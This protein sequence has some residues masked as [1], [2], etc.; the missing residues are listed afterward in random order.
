MEG[1]LYLCPT[2]IGNLEDITLRVIHTLEACQA[3]YCEDTRRTGQLLRHLGVAK[4]LVSCH[5]HNEAQRG[6]EIVE[7]VLAGEAIAYASDAGMP[8][9]SDPGERLIQRCQAAGAPYEVL[10][11]PSASLTALV[12]SGL[13]S[14]RRYS[15]GFCPA[16]ARN[17]GNGS[18]GWAA[19]RAA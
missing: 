9:I 14:R 4:P 2:P 18:P 10:P 1:K 6:Q 16:A 17:A 15:W 11:G 19:R 5:A 8:G 12:A 3:V 13:P 7:R